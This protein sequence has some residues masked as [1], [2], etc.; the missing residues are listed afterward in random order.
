MIGIKEAEEYLKS[1]KEYAL[2]KGWTEEQWNM[3]HNHIYGAAN[4]AKKLA[5]LIKKKIMILLKIIW[6]IIP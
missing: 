1:I 5:D 2:D 4:L 6:R 3:Y